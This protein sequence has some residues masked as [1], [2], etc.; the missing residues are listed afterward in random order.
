MLV[1]QLPPWDC[2]IRL[3]RERIPQMRFTN[4]IKGFCH[5][6]RSRVR[7]H[8]DPPKRDA[9]K[10]LFCILSGGCDAKPS[11]AEAVPFCMAVMCCIYII[12]YAGVCIFYFTKTSY[13][14]LIFLPIAL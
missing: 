7:A 9:E 13:D 8:S 12:P 11:H 10:R 1:R 5:T 2:R 6:R 14:F 3:H 4:S